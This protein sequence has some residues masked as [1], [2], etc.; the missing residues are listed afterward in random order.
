MRTGRHAADACV[1]P[2]TLG[3]TLNAQ[4]PPP[5]VTTSP[6]SR[7]FAARH[8]PPPP[9]PLP[10]PPLA[11]IGVWCSLI[12]TSRLSSAAQPLVRSDGSRKATS[13]QR[14]GV[15]ST[16]AF[17]AHGARPR[18]AVVATRESDHPLHPAE[19]FTATHSV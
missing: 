14:I 1:Q 17:G 9:P 5:T 7:V 8:S 4:P 18:A 19:F 15:A 11:S 10:P 12:S 6:S 3:A 2:A 16:G 13:R